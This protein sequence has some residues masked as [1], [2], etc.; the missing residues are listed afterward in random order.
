MAEFVL[1]GSY[2]FT[3]YSCLHWSDHLE[4]ATNSLTVEELTHQM[5]LGM[6]LN[7]FIL[8]NNPDPVSGSK[9]Y[10]ELS[11]K[12]DQ[13]K[14]SECYDTL[15]HL[16][17][18]AKTARIANE[19]L[20]T[21]GPLGDTVARVRRM[22]H[23][24]NSS[25]DLDEI[26]KQA[27]QLYYGKNLYKCSRHACYYFHEGFAN[28]SLLEQHTSRH[29]K[30]YCCTEIGC[31][32]MYIGWATEKDLKKHKSQYHPDPES[33]AFKFPHVKKMP[34]VFQ[35]ESC[36]KVYSR[37]SSL[38]IHVQREHLKERKFLCKVCGKSFV[39]KYDCD[40]HEGTHDSGTQ[41]PGHSQAS[42]SNRTNPEGLNATAPNLEK[43]DGA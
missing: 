42:A 7:E 13:L 5:P 24:L 8:L 12:C 41:S 31:T 20:E 21:L 2:A 37:A 38:K 27:L 33:L 25:P 22:L 17:S 9:L 1:D 32:R 4:S 28:E 11:K 26:A 39:T 14:A 43:V 23:E 19:K 15:L 40:R 29:D 16:I 18:S 35:C 36:P 3:D 10:E 34:T 6:A 30:P